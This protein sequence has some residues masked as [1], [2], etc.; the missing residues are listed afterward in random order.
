MCEVY[1][2]SQYS[3]RSCICVKCI[4][5]HDLSLYWLGWYT[6][7]IYIFSHFTGLVDTLHKYIWSLT[8]LAW[9][10][11]FTN[12]H[13]LS[14]YWHSWY[15]SHIYIFSHFTGLVDTLHKYT[16]A[17][18][19]LAWLIHFTHIHDLSLYWLGWCTSHIYMISHLTGL[20]DTL[21]TYTSSLTLLYINQ[22]S[23]VNDHVYV[24]SLSTKPVRWTIMYMCEVYQPSQ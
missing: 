24:W 14:L 21:H 13:D 22:A 1:Q 10:I 17:L 7:H 11:H 8:L 16:F 23:K 3:E 12:I 19:L 2:P 20:V 6:S 9:L 18:T 5:I 15:T 4:N